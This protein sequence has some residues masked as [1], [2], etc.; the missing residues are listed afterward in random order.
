MSSIPDFKS[1]FDKKIALHVERY[2]LLIGGTELFFEK[3]GY[4][5]ELSNYMQ[6]INDAHL[7]M[8]LPKSGGMPEYLE[9]ARKRALD[10][11]VPVESCSPILAN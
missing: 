11:F 8:G 3:Q 2:I 9:A 5:Q 10:L 6:G 1:G 4:F 7:S